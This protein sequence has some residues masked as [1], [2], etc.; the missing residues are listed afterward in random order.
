MEAQQE[1]PA[2][3]TPQTRARRAWIAEAAVATAAAL[4]VTAPAW[5]SPGTVVGDVHSSLLAEGSWALTRLPDVLREG[6]GFLHTTQVWAMS[7]GE[8]TWTH[9]RLA[10]LQ[11]LPFYAVTSYPLVSSLAAVA[12]VIA[13][14]LASAWLIRVAGAGRVLALAGAL[15]TGAGPYVVGELARG[16]LG[17]ATVWPL[18]LA[19]AGWIAAIRA[20]TPRGSWRAAALTILA[21]CLYTPY[22]LFVLGAAGMLAAARWHAERSFE[23]LRPLVPAASISSVVLLVLLWAS[24]RALATPSSP[25]AAAIAG[26]LPF[27]SLVW[28]PA[29]GAS[30]DWVPWLWLVLAGVGWVF[31]E[32]AEAPWILRG[33]GV[34]SVVSWVLALGPC[35]VTADGVAA[36]SHMPFHVV[37]GLFPL[38]RWFVAPY[39]HLAL[40]GMGVATVGA[41]GI[42]TYTRSR[43]RLAGAVAVLG[44]LGLT[45]EPMARGLAVT[46]PVSRLAL[47]PTWVEEFAELPPGIMLFTPLE[48]RMRLHDG[49]LLLSGPLRHAL[50]TGPRPWDDLARPAAFDA[51]L[52]RSSFLSELQRFE[53]GQ[54]I[55]GDPQ[56]ANRFTYDPADLQALCDGGLRWV[57]VWDPMY[58]RL[59]QRLAPATRQLFQTLSGAPILQGEGISV[60][61]LT[62]G[63]P[64][65]NVT[66]PAWRMPKGVVIGSGS[67]PME[68]HPMAPGPYEALGKP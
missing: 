6:A 68:G 39:Q 29:D 28:P 64:A 55:A 49:D 10:A 37:Y 20:P 24:S 31:R 51:L 30:R 45:M 32:R 59:I 40:L 34:A 47:S 38:L 33:L 17:S 1:P 15:F 66:A 52:E 56:R 58:A 11:A 44:V 62:H 27:H 16:D 13:N 5:H 21:A 65:G 36:G 9:G 53:R 22:G 60:Y 61:D 8:A 43:P 4:A 25:S 18:A 48:G 50:F 41:V 14:V 46:A 2:V 57:V 35:L 3:T 54:E 23:A 42:D 7:G 63:D 12:V 26:S 19:L 67:A